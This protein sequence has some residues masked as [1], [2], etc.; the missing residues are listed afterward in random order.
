MLHGS[1]SDDMSLLPLTCFDPSSQSAYCGLRDPCNYTA[2]C[3]SVFAIVV[4]RMLIKFFLDQSS[5]ILVGASVR[6]P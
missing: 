5:Q 3:E 6:G 4:M 1:R 2:D